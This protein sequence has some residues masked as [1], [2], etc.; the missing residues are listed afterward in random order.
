MTRMAT[1]KKTMQDRTRLEAVTFGPDQPQLPE[2]D[3]H[4]AK[5]T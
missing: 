2:A 5:G 4:T 1:R 3:T